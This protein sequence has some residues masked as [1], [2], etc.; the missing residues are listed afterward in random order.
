MSVPAG[1]PQG[2]KIGPWLFL[3]MINDLTIGELPA[4]MWKFADDTTVSEVAKKDGASEL[5]GTVHELSEWTNLNRFQLNPTKCKEMII[6]FKKQPCVYTSLN[7]NNQSFEVVNA[8]KLL[9]VTIT[10]DLNYYTR[11]A[12]TRSVFICYKTT[13]TS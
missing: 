6:S 12:W 3:A 9:G 5:Q 8:A 7:V 2:T 10:Q 13:Q 11:S 4:E 1:I